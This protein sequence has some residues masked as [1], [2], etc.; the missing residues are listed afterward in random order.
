MM[1]IIKPG[2]SATMGKMRKYCVEKGKIPKK[3]KMKLTEDNVVSKWNQC[4]PET[5]N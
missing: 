5:A 2:S 4:F 1:I 3:D